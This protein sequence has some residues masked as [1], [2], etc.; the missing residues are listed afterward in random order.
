MN[1][2][3][4][5]RLRFD[6]AKQRLGEDPEVYKDRLHKYYEE[7]LLGDEPKF[8]KKY[9]CSVYNKVM[10]GLLRTHKPTLTTIE[11]LEKEI[12][13]YVTQLQIYAETAPDAAPAVIA[14]L[15]GMRYGLDK[16]NQKARERIWAL[17][18]PSDL[19][20][21][22]D[23]DDIVTTDLGAIAAEGNWSGDYEADSQSSDGLFSTES[24]H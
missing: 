7:T 17:Y 6:L 14:G 24:D 19:V 23:I 13:Y 1:P 10:G 9:V 4:L 20:K 11:A 21:G 12:P 16:G 22:E 2:E 5:R 18:H 8:I 3:E 15:G